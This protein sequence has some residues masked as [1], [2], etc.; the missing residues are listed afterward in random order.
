MKNLLVLVVLLLL[1]AN[2][3]ALEV[4][5]VSIPETISIGSHVLKLNGYGIR[6]KFFVSVYVG[7]LYTAATVSSLAEALNDPDDKLIR[8]VFVHKKVGRDKIVEAFAEGFARNTPELSGSSEARQFLA[9]FRNDFSSGD[10][11]DLELGKSGKVVIRHNDRVLG[12]LESPLLAQGI[13]AIY[14]GEH[15]ADDDLKKGMLGLNR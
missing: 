15:P 1:T 3:Q 9:L 11:V 12:A 14:L 10:T 13:L 6:K 2:S 4:A 7:S 5:G 8:M